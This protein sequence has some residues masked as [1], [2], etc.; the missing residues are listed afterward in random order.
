MSE[1]TENDGNTTMKSAGNK[2]KDLYNNY[3]RNQEQK[4]NL[5]N[6]E[7]DEENNS[8]ENMDDNMENETE[9]ENIEKILTQLEKERDEFRDKALR[10]TAEMEN[11]RK[12]TL[13][14]K[15]DLV[16]YANEHLL[17]KFLPLLDDMFAALDAGKQK[18]DYESLIT[19]FELIMQKTLKMF[20]NAGVKPMEDAVGK[21]FDV[22]LQE[23]IMHIPSE[24]PEG[25]VVQVVQ[26]GFMIRDKVLRH[27]KVI[28]SAG[29]SN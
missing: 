4:K 28:T 17:L 14:E 15:Q 24:L 8:P 18:T 29:Q 3:K 6:N 27:A 10:I 26:P 13:K 19:G 1:K 21:P 16:E 23:A 7:S 2:V 5:T 11:F 20:E 9:T 25:C 12:R 22:N